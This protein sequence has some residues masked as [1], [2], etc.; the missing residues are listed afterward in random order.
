MKGQTMKKLI[1]IC[2]A[3]GLCLS[4]A[5]TSFGAPTVFLDADT[6][7]TGSLLGTQPL[8][9]PY[10]TITLVY[11]QIRD[12]DNDLEFN[13]AGASGNVF[14]ILGPGDSPP[15]DQHAELSFDFDVLSVMFI[16]G[17]NEGSILVEARDASSTVLDSFYQ[18]YTDEGQ[19]AGPVTLS[20]LGIRSLYW[21]DTVSGMSFAALDNITLTTIIPAP[22]AIALGSIGVAFVGWLRRRRIL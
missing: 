7:A 16:Y 1:T 17:G 15:G 20:G 5:T 13:A 22:G 6:P 9:T 3:V 11:G 4:V 10:G 8:V 14:D 18:A 12:R 19:P 2:I 21:K